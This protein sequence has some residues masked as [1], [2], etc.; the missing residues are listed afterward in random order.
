[1]LSTA[2]S[3]CFLTVSQEERAF[4]PVTG[5]PGGGTTGQWDHAP[6][7]FHINKMNKQFT[8]HGFAP[9]RC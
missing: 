4:F 7:E 3:V 8:P 5:S 6:G 1:M 2:D 9:R